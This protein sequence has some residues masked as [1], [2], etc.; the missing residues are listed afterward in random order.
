MQEVIFLG[1]L[2]LIWIIFATI[3]DIKTREIA[4]WLNYS[5]IIFALGFRFFYCFFEAGDFNFFYQG[6]IGLGIFF[7]LGNIFYYLRM[8][9]GGDY[10]LFVAL[11]VILP[12][13]VSF[14]INLKIFVLFLLLFLIIGAIYGLFMT[15]F[16]AVKNFS[17]FRKKFVEEF[18]KSRKLMILILFLAIFILMISFY[19]KGIMGLSILVFLIPYLYIFAKAVDE[20]V[21]VRK[22]KVSKL[23]EGDWLHK[24]IKIGRKVIK[25]T[26]DGL[27]KED[28]VF[29]RNKKKEVFM[30]A[31]VQ[32]GP[33]FLISFILL[34]FIFIFKFSFLW[35]SFW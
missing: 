28:I 10:R 13:D 6:L 25:A 24:D 11:G 34:I 7:V 20:G 3:Q 26:W 27:T 31:G 29:L 33:V 17:K 30:R 15:C 9:A 22:I 2:A 16:F 8:F 23:T 21:M 4:S 19:I 1:S 12:L 18:K 14:L 32:F 35:N 5:L